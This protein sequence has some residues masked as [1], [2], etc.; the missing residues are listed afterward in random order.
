MKRTEREHN[1]DRERPAFT[2]LQPREKQYAQFSAA[3]MGFC[4]HRVDKERTRM[5]WQLAQ[6]L[7]RQGEPREAGRR[8]MRDVQCITNGVLNIRFPPKRERSKRVGRRVGVAIKNTQPRSQSQHAAR[9]GAEIVKLT[10]LSAMERRCSEAEYSENTWPPTA[11]FIWARAISLLMSYS[12]HNISSRLEARFCHRVLSLLLLRLQPRSEHSPIDQSSPPR[13]IYKSTTWRASRDGQ[14]VGQR[15]GSESISANASPSASLCSRPVFRFHPNYVLTPSFP[16]SFR[17]RALRSPLPGGETPFLVPH[18]PPPPFRTVEKIIGQFPAQHRCGAVRTPARVHLRRPRRGAASNENAH[19]RITVRS[20]CH[21]QQ[22]APQV[23]NYF[24]PSLLLLEH[25]LVSVHS[26]ALCHAQFSA[27]HP[28]HFIPSLVPR[29]APSL[30][31][32]SNIFTFVPRRCPLVPLIL[33]LAAHAP[34]STLF[35]FAPNT[36]PF[37]LVRPYS[38]LVTLSNVS[39]STCGRLCAVKPTCRCTKRRSTALVSPPENAYT[40]AARRA[41]MGKKQIG[42]FFV[43]LLNDQPTTI[44]PFWK[45]PNSAPAKMREQKSHVQNH[46]QNPAPAFLREQ[47]SHVKNHPQNPAPAK[48]REQKSL[49]KN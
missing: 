2:V 41:D 35:H 32:P 23:D 33:S 44:P 19:C 46:P 11:R 30:I 42:R 22:A 3:S 13:R 12:G 21:I 38:V 20:L 8:P 36:H 27:I 1:W 14:D 37:A 17:K 49:A 24:R 29:R 9:C 15:G 34:V 43:L 45:Q 18:T 5:K 28:P 26:S 47:K 25:A 16:P 10:A 39:R 4:S 7:R 48:K 6:A 31:F 40:D